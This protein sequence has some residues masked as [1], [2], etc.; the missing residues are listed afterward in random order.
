VS[1]NCEEDY[2]IAMAYIA[3]QYTFKRQ[4]DL[5]KLNIERERNKM[6]DVLL[7]FLEMS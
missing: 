5:D 4:L 1:V 2:L 7:R 6:V 3:E